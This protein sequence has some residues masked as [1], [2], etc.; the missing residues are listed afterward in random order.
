MKG[1]LSM[2]RVALMFGALCSILAIW[3][4]AVRPTELKVAVGPDRTPMLAYAEAMARLMRE[5]RQ[6]VRL[7]V[8]R[9]GDSEDASKLLDS[10]KVDLALLRSD[11]LTSTDARSIVIVNKRALIL[12]AKKTVEIKSM[13][14]LAGKRIVVAMGDGDSN[15]P[16]IQRILSHYDI[17][18]D[19]LEI[20]ELPRAEIPAGFA[21]DRFDVLILLSNPAAKASRTML[22]EI[23]G[24]QNIEL[25]L[26]GASGHEALALRFNEL[27]TFQVPEGVFGGSLPDEDIDTV[28]ITHELV[29]SSRMSEQTAAALTKSLMELRGRLRRGGDNPLSVDTPPVDEP[30]RFLPHAGTAAYVNS[31]AKTLLEAYSDHIWLALFSLGIVGSSIAGMLSWAGLRQEAAIDTVAGEMRALAGRLEQASS[32]AEIDAIQGDFDDL[33]LAIMREYGLRTLSEEGT[34]DPSPWL[35]TFAGLIARRRALLQDMNGPDCP[36]LGPVAPVD[37]ASPAQ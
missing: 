12:A 28:A 21:A 20:E 1:P 30:R 17:D 22:A 19:Q 35:A 9:A 8:V 11:D 29:A 33:V 34:P 3:Y 14:D 18:A 32:A 24:N 31:E 16:I 6:P 13:R 27:Q 5:T 25:V 10:R 23:T 7:K 26:S 37:R 36:T 2:R 4:L 15:L